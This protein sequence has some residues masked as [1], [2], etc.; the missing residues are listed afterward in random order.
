MG[1][2][3]AMRGPQVESEGAIPALQAFNKCSQTI[4]CVVGGR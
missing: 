4:Y 2:L 1:G 3:D